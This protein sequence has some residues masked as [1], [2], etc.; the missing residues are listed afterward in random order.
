MLV[1]LHPLAARVVVRSRLCKI[2]NFNDNLFVGRTGSVGTDRLLR[3]IRPG[4]TSGGTLA[5]SVRIVAFRSATPLSIPDSYI[6]PQ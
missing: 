3:P 4:D 5:Q 6:D 1:I 2:Y